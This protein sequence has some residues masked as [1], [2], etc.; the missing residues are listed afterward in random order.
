MGNN[1]FIYAAKIFAV[2]LTPV[3]V[4]SACTTLVFL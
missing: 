4:V 1:K 3:A 2:L